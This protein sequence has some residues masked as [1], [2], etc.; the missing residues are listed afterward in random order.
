MNKP[1]YIALDTLADVKKFT[2]KVAE[3]RQY[4]SMDLE[5]SGLNPWKDDI[6][7]VGLAATEAGAV[8]IPIA[9]SYYQPYDGRAAME[10]LKE[11]F[12]YAPFVGFNV[13]FDVEF[14]EYR[15]GI[16][17]H[18]DFIDSSLLTYVDG[19]IPSNSLEAQAKFHLNM[20]VLSF[21][22]FMMKTDLPLKSVNIADAPIAHVAAYC[23]RDTLAAFLLFKKLYPRLKNDKIYKLERDLVPVIRWLRRNGVLVNQDYFVKEQTRITREKE[24]LTQLLYSQVYD[25]CSQK[26]EFNPRS[27]AQVAEV[28]FRQIG[29]PVQGRSRKTKAPSTSENALAPL[30]WDYP[31]V[32]NLL[33]W[34]EMDKRLTSYLN[35]YH[36]LVQKDGRIHASY[37][38]TGVI[39]GRFSSSDPNMQ[40]VPGLKKWKIM[41]DKE[42]IKE[43]ETNTRSG[44]LVPDDKWWLSFDFSQIEARLAAGVTKEPVLLNAFEQGIDFHTKTASLIFNV[45]VDKVKY[46]QR[47]LGKKLNFLMLY[48]GEAKRLYEELVKEERVTR[49]QAKQYRDEYYHIYSTMFNAAERI[50]REAEQTCSVR[51]IYNRRVPIPNLASADNYTRLKGHRQA[52]NAIIQGSAGDIL[53]I[54]MCKLYDMIQEDFSLDAVKL[55]ST[56]H[57]SQDYEIDEHVDMVDLIKKTMP[58]LTYNLEGFPEITSDVS[59]GKNWGSL[60]EREKDETVETFV[61]RVTG[62]RKKV[63]VPVKTSE[64]KAESKFIPQYDFKTFIWELSETAIQVNSKA[65]FIEAKSWIQ[66]RLGKG[67]H[68]LILRIGEKESV[69]TDMNISLDDADTLKLML[70]GKLYEQKTKT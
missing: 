17:S 53:K 46:E 22:E 62:K 12:E 16:Q 23:G 3:K 7:G 43:M 29:L 35:K 49:E 18:L 70:G 56:V 41:L 48:G 65:N 45:P 4:Y 58:L 54:S 20:R 50:G 66:T 61:A 2:S 9:H 34:R 19:Q 51:T 10:I 6:V 1:K 33:I 67:I 13:L 44:F 30:R 31:L 25:M 36:N 57:D 11:L 21:K 5:T 24:E 32:N 52:Y 27:S 55:F 63:A 42:K 39:T 26:V 68:K 40:N 8:Y 60:K 14:L 64:G 59:L 47:Q 28:L 37:N 69:F 38:Q 15:A